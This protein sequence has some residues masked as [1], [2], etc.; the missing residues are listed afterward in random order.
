MKGNNDFHLNQATVMEAIQDYLNK[1]MGD[2]APEVIC[3][4]PKG[5]ILVV[6]TSERKP[7]P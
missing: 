6:A 5:D 3:I 4:V 1:H 2:K 7:S